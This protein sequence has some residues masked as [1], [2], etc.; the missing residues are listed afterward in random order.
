MAGAPRLLAQLPAT[1][2]AQRLPL[3]NLQAGLDQ[4]EQAWQRGETV[5]VLA[6]G[7]P[8]FFGLGRLLLR[9]FPA[10]ALVFHPHLSSVQLVFSRLRLPWQD[11]RLISVHGRDLEPVRQ[12]CQQGAAK[13]AILTDTINSPGA[14]AALLAQLHLPHHY[15]IWVGENLGG[16]TERVEQYPEITELTHQTFAPLSV[17]V[18]LRQ[19][20]DESPIRQ[21]DLPLL[22]LPD[23]L[24][25]SF[26]DRPGLMTKREIRIAILGEL[27]LTAQCQVIWDL[28]AGTGSVAIEMARLASQA[29]VYAVEKTAMGVS[30]IAQN[31][32]RFGVE[33]VEAIAGSAPNALAELPAP[34]RIFIGGSGGQ[35][36]E[37]LDAAWSRLK[38]QGKLVA[39]F[40]TLE[41][42]C[43]AWQW[44]KAQQIT[45]QVLQLQVARS[46]PFAQ[47]HR[48]T[49]LN[50]VT[51]LTITK[52]KGRR[53]KDEG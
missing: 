36:R 45:A 42:F 53:M 29:Q 43:T 7:D 31:C 44:C 16:E 11:A 19:A 4:I 20:P 13:I 35:L 10:D 48:L 24:F 18:L 39:A 28:G 8:L 6:S 50:P 49:P 12:C 1:H 23:D 9:Q 26:A 41:H 25:L 37:I 14:I 17:V 40:A 5:V 33:T 3:Q 2:L 30:L 32:D 47:L 51:L 46:L 52:D 27:A 34:D 38:L 15:D 21:Q 22:G